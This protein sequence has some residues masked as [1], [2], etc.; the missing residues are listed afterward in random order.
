[1]AFNVSA[2]TAYVDQSSEQILLQSQIG[3]VTA[4]LVN[5]QTGI[6]GTSALQL[7][8]TDLQVQDGTACGYNSAGTT[9]MTQR[10]IVTAAMKVNEDLCPRDLEAKW[11]QILLSDCQHYTANPDAIAEAYMT[12]KL[13]RLCDYLE[14]QD[15]QGDT[16]Q[17][18]SFYDGLI[19]IIDAATGVIDGNPTSIAAGTG[20]TKG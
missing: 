7:M 15:W 8:S 14:K 3:C 18:G 6:K 2:L 1:M 17:S 20:I 12:D 5:K 13:N 19:K 4:N 9:A 10:N 11:T 16:T